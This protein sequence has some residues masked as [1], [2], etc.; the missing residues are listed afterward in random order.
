MLV[1]PKAITALN[2][3]RSGPYLTQNLFTPG[4][5]TFTRTSSHL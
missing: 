5:R 2:A 3:L 4:D 1:I